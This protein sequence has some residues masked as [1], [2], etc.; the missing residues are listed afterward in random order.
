LK[1]YEL[2][3]LV[4]LVG[5]L[6]L[7]G[8]V[9]GGGSLLVCYWLGYAALQVGW[10]IAAGIGFVVGVAVLGVGVRLQQ[11]ARDQAD[12]DGVPYARVY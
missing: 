8:S 1:W 6:L 7:K 10:L 5:A 3:E 4:G 11:R 12:R 2:G 9:V